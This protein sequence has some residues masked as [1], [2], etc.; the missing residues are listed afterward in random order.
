MEIFCLLVYSPNDHSV[1]GLARPNPEARNV[2]W[3]CHVGDRN[4]GTWATDRYFPSGLVMALDQTLWYGILAPSVAAVPQ[5]LPPNLTSFSLISSLLASKNDS[6]K[7]LK[8]LL[9]FF[10]N[11]CLW[12]WLCGIQ[13]CLPFHI[14]PVCSILVI[15]TSFILCSLWLPFSSSSSL[16]D[17]YPFSSFHVSFPILRE[18]CQPEMPLEQPLLL[19]TEHS[20]ALTPFASLTHM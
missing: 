6:L 12:A 7:G 16:K 11:Q 18:T 15:P 17:C 10:L 5:S 20:A 9:F 2:I 19:Q 1:Q 4:S 8:E 3:V 14:L 13:L